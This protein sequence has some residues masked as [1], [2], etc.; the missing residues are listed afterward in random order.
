L[1]ALDATL[2]RA[3]RVSLVGWTTPTLIMST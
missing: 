1:D 2:G 3:V